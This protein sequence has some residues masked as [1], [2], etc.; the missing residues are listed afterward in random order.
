ML[1][2]AYGPIEAPTGRQ[3]AER[4]VV[5]VV[6]RPRSGLAGPAQRDA[7]SI[8]RQAVQGG[9]LAALHPRT[10]VQVVLQVEADDGGVLACAANAAG[11]A[12]VDAGIP[13]SSQLG[14]EDRVVSYSQT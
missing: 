10:I 6:F 11:A 12:L 8:V 4:A 5:E 2:A 1:A 9:V 3:D 7:E 13:M 14:E